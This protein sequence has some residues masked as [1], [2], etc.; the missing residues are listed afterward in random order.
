MGPVLKAS[1]G[2]TWMTWR[3]TTWERPGSDLGLMEDD[4]RVME[5]DFEVMGK[6]LRD[7][8]GTDDL[9][10]MEDDL[11]LMEDNLRAME[12]DLEVM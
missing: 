1:D 6:G 12:D 8:G 4:L 3:K 5:D 2:N 7:D 9:A 11:G 10:A